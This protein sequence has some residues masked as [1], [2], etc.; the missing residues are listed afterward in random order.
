MAKVTKSKVL[1][2]HASVHSI[3]GKS[4]FSAHPNEIRPQTVQAF[5]SE[6]ELTAQA[7]QQLQASG[8]NVLQ[9]SPTTI[10]IAAP[11]EVYETAF[12]TKITRREEPVV[13]EEGKE[14]TAEM[15]DSPSTDVPGLIDPGG[16]PFADVLEGVSLNRP[17]YYFANKFAPPVGYWHLRIP[18]DVSLG[19]NA[20]RAHR[21]GF[22]GQGIHAVMVDS[23]WY[24]HPY[25]VA[26]GYRINPVVLGP[27]AAA[28]EHDENGHGTGE[29]ANLLAVAPDVAFTMV[30]MSFV[31]SAGAFQAAVALNP[32]IISCS[33]GSDVQ[34]GPLRSDDNVL[35]AAVADAV[36]RGI[37]VVCSGGN[38]HFGFPG[39]HPDVIAAGGV[40]LQPD[41]S[42]RASDYAS[43][44]ASLV[45][46]GRTVPDVS[47]LVG[48]QPHGAYIML[49]VEPR[50]QIDTGGAGGVHPARDQTLSYDG[51]AAF[52][53]TSAAAPQLAGICALMKQANSSLTLADARAILQRTAIDV[54]LGSSHPRTGGVAGVG[55]D[56]A[57]GAGLADAHKATM[58]ARLRA[59]VLPPGTGVAPLTT[60]ADP[61]TLLAPG[62]LTM[63]EYQAF[64]DM[65][66]GISH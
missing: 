48:M 12:K 37:I 24:Q 4:L 34:T 40:F 59:V 9:V 25:F 57:T 15:F 39:Q 50:N 35:A 8:F 60:P 44:F 64:E 26:R 11:V 22:T 58:L 65:L 2:A 23:G 17:V 51:W 46:P 63:D 18:G 36:R 5:R 45:F 55:P 3:G 62:K 53:G 31:D 27:G 47:G 7:V 49:P 21:A 29:S 43:G 38:G 52:S 16:S 41:G 42:L 13:K 56:L 54:T 33:W 19:L 6:K 32:H 10:A 66:L 61:S 20:D 1:F 30:K 14:T 28:P